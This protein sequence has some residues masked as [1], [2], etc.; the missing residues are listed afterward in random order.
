MGFWMENAMQPGRHTLVDCGYT[1]DAEHRFKALAPLIGRKNFER[2]GNDRLVARI[3]P[4]K[5]AAV[6]AALPEI[7]EGSAGYGWCTHGFIEKTHSSPAPAR[8]QGATT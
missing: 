6:L 1:K 4:R 7:S 5:K 2:V 3:P 8:K